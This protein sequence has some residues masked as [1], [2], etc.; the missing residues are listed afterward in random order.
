MSLR[1]CSCSFFQDC[2]QDSW[3]I[4]FTVLIQHSDVQAPVAP[5]QALFL[6]YAL[7]FSAFT[8]SPGNTWEGEKKQGGCLC[9]VIWRSSYVCTSEWKSTVCSEEENRVNVWMRRTAAG[10][11]GNC[12][13]ILHKHRKSVGED[14]LQA[15]RARERLRLGSC[16]ALTIPIVVSLTSWSDDSNAFLLL[17]YSRSLV[18]KVGSGPVAYEA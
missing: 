17:H 8:C 4:P 16:R 1:L 6:L 14:D 7:L 3:L 15:Q 10:Y 11:S 12:T 5:S 2:L 13:V 18:P 9:M